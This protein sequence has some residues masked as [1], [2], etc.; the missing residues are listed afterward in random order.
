MPTETRVPPVLQEHVWEQFVSLNEE[1][2]CA[3]E[4]MRH[5]FG[6]VAGPHS[7]PAR[8]RAFAVTLRELA[9]E[10]DAM[11]QAGHEGGAG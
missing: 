2:A 4:I 3:L 5:L 6:I 10:Y 9:V 1:D 11:A 8:L 7:P